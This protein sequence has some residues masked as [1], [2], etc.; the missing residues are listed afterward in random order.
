MSCP[1]QLPFLEGSLVGNSQILSMC[2]SHFLQRHIRQLFDRLII[3]VSSVVIQASPPGQ[4]SVFNFADGK[5]EGACHLP[6]V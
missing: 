3:L 4:E 1:T 5:Y 2:L 6:E